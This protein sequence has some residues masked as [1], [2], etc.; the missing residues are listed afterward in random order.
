MH[1]ISRGFTVLFSSLGIS[2]YG[3]RSR[4]VAGCMIFKVPL[5]PLSQLQ[6]STVPGWCGADY[7][8]GTRLALNAGQDAKMLAG[9][10]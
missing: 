6:S 7:I 8:Q 1:C 9:D 4:V 10:R 3:E 5:G 2:D